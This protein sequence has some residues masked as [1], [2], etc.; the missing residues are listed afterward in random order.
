MVTEMTTKPRNFI[1][2]KGQPCSFLFLPQEEKLLQ[3]LYIPLNFDI[4][5]YMD[6]MSKLE[7]K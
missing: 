1:Y 3:I 2:M 6:K 4:R 7:Q 5:R